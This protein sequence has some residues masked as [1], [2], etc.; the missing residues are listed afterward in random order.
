MADSV[1]L[2]RLSFAARDQPPAI[3]CNHYYCSKEGKLR[4]SGCKKVFYWYVV[5]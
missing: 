5:S 1:I 2:S 3:S 4:C